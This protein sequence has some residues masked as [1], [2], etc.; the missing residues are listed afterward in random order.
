MTEVDMTEF[1]Y[2]LDKIISEN[3][4]ENGCSKLR[5]LFDSY[6]EDEL[7]E[8]MRRYK[9]LFSE[10]KDLV[11]SLEFMVNVHLEMRKNGY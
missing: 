5:M 4:L 3:A 7:L 1:L 2:H 11:I 10:Y 9:E 8:I 6:S